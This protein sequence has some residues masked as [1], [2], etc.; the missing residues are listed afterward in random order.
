[1]EE[2]VQFSLPVRPWNGQPWKMGAQF[3]QLG[4]PGPGQYRKTGHGRGVQSFLAWQ[5]HDL[6]G[7]G[8]ASQE[9]G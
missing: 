5:N 7:S 3:P 4:I 8:E 1:M 6:S 9:H 2:G